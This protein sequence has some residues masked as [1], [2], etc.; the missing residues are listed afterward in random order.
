[1]ESKE[2]IIIEFK[3]LINQKLPSTYNKPVRLNHCFNRIILDW[4][5]KD[6]WY[7]HL[8]KNKIA[9]S[10]LSEPQLSQAILRMKQWL[11]NQQLLINDNVAS[12][13]YRKK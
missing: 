1:M 4:L 5:F 6:C 11:S 13:Y 9:L 7:N 3:Q 12:L 8:D 2:S 10:Q